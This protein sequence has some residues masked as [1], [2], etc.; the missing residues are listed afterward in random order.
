MHFHVFYMGCSPRPPTAQE[1]FSWARNNHQA[2][3]ALICA[4]LPYHDA[5]RPGI[6]FTARKYCLMVCPTHMQIDCSIA[7]SGRSP[8][9]RR[10]RN[11]FQQPEIITKS[12]PKGIASTCCLMPPTVQGF[13]QSLKI[14]IQ[15][16]PNRFMY[17]LP[18]MRPSGVSHTSQPAGA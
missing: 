9:Y 12:S 16:P 8:G 15:Y 7:V 10:P 14:I 5:F 18:H 2:L 17:S 6:I 3:P 4:D 11:Y 1:L 13:F